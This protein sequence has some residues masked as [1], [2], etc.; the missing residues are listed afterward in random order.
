M[1]VTWGRNCSRNIFLNQQNARNMKN[2]INNKKN[3]I[4][5]FIVTQQSFK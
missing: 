5:N 4:K 2:T 1:Q 3:F